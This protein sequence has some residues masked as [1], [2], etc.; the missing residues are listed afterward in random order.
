MGGKAGAKYQTYKTSVF[1]HTEGIMVGA[2]CGVTA[3]SRLHAIVY[4]KTLRKH[5][6]HLQQL[7]MKMHCGHKIAPAP[8][9]VKVRSLCARPTNCVYARDVIFIIPTYI[10][11]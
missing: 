8:A 6:W 9:L 3:R 10:K 4:F 7:P 2:K 1:V 11:A 5:D